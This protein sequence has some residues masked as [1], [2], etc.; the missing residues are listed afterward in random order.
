MSVGK[1]LP[2]ES[3]AAHVQ[4]TARYTDDQP[5]FAGMLSAWPVL[6]PHARARI[7]ALDTAPA[8]EVPGV[9]HVLTYRDVPGE[10]DS[11]AHKGDEPLLPEHEVLFH[12]QAVAWVLAETDEAARAGAL[13][14]RA[15]YEP[16]TPILSIQDAIAQESFHGSAQ[17]L[18]R[19]DVDTAL[20]NAPNRLSG[21]L[22][23]GGQDHFYLET[24]VSWAVPDPD[25][26]VHITSSTQHPS[27]TQGVVANV[28]GVPAHQ[29]TVTCLRMGGG[30]GGK[31]S[32]AAPYAALAALGA[33][34]I[35]RPVRVRLRREHDMVLSGKRHPFWGRYE[36]GFS[37]EGIL[38]GMR[39][40]LYSDGGFSS[41]LS[42]PVMGR[43][44]FHA[45]NA[46]FTP[47]LHVS[48]QVCK[49]HKVSQTA[50]RGFG[51]PQGMLFAEEIV[52]RIAQHLGL[53]AE[54]VRE[55]NF[56]R[57]TGE[58]AT[59]HYGQEIT[60]NRLERVWREV[61]ERSAFTA[62]QREVAA[63]N[64]AH[65]H[66]KR[67]LAVTPVK[68]GIS[69]T[70]TPMNQAGA[71]VLVYQ[72]GSVQLNHGGTE[73][74]QGLY[75]KMLQVAAQ[76]LGVP[77][78][79]FR[80]MPT[81]TDKI[82]NTSPTA[83]S[84]GSDLNGQ[85]V[86]A[87][88]ETLRAR[89]AGVA[90]RLLELSSPDDLIFEGGEVFSPTQPDKRL[91]F[92]D[93]VRRAYLEQVPLFATGFYRTPNLHFNPQT[94]KGRPF[95][96]FAYGAAVSEVEVDGFTGQFRLCRVDIVEDAGTSLNPLVDRGQ[97][98]GGFVQGLGWLT[99]E[100]TL[101]DDA[102]RFVTNAP[103]VYKIPTIADVPDTF[104]VTLLPRAAQEGVIYGS[105]AVG[106][107][108]FMLALSVREA[109]RDAVAAFADET[110]ERVDLP[111]PATPEAVL[112]A[113]EAVKK[114]ARE[115]VSGD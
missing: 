67:G 52:A 108:P 73:M 8:L 97:I 93:V 78:S 91:L 36:V 30:F 33:F 98:E 66:T 99:M 58:S 53:P 22:F 105:K 49:T 35:G 64:A 74:G 40:E 62:R 16:L 109:I 38:E 41:D 4:G 10:N 26:S 47:N 69:F 84:S 51:G 76:A 56:Y 83:A 94:G 59:T 110:P 19:G 9:V 34:V 48:G 95:H 15:T 23:V 5:R 81:A 20:K 115:L 43:A 100:E 6:A 12:S 106:E 103:S 89:L 50:F 71:L 17:V 111:S 90:A 79:Q 113:L 11:S 3:A 42:L 72:D 92:L 102:G 87:A 61:L 29:V 80:A 54:R 68:F 31:E 46:Y 28:L 21:K 104:N 39:L 24:H 86:L 114:P 27:E 65:P 63:F 13:L 85:A 7:T 25:G 101:W 32:Q 44:L 77:M 45:D 2:H 112:W 37:D 60:D 75:T 1:A 55:H 96:Y 18:S 57:G 88:C 107:P 82:P 70:N 14:V